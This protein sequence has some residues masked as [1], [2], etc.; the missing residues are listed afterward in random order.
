MKK[1][2]LTNNV[3]GTVNTNRDKKKRKT[4]GE[5]VSIAGCIV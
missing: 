1:T 3:M 5:I 4:K 2:F